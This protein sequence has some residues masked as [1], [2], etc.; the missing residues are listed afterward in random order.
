[1]ARISKQ[2]DFLKTALRLPRDLHAKIHEAADE[3]G[4]SMNAEIVARLEQSFRI[5]ESVVVDEG[6]RLVEHTNYQ[7]SLEDFAALKEM[8]KEKKNG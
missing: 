6:H 4:R 2:E 1:M 7:L 3:A 5:V 8:I